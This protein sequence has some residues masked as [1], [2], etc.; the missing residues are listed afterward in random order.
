MTHV[1]IHTMAQKIKGTY[2]LLLHLEDS[3]DL[4][5]GA[6]GSRQLES[7]WY[8]YVGSAQNGLYQR[9]NR[10]LKS[11]KKKHWHIDYLLE[12]CRV[13]QIWM[14]R[15]ERSFECETAKLL[16]GKT[17]YIKGFGCSDCRCISHLFYGKKEDF[18][19]LLRSFNYECFSVDNFMSGFCVLEAR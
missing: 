10:H 8:V 16:E 9:I 4:S 12:H 2:A 1:V 3:F 7:G 5:I 6:L 15:S 19:A 18:Q 13:E 14:L 17:E 11:S